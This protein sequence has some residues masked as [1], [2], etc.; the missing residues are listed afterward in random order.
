MRN[1]KRKLNCTI[2]SEHPSFLD[3]IWEH[4]A[5][6][7]YNTPKHP[8]K[9]EQNPMWQHA[10]IS[11]EVYHPTHTCIFGTRFREEDIE[12]WGSFCQPPREA[13]AREAQRTTRE[14]IK[15]AALLTEP[16]LHAPNH[17]PGGFGVHSTDLV[18]TVV[19]LDLSQIRFAPLH[20]APG[21]WLL[22]PSLK[23]CLPLLRGRHWRSRRCLAAATSTSTTNPILK[24]NL[25]AE[26][27]AMEG[28]IGAAGYRTPNRAWTHLHL[29][30]LAVQLY[31]P[32]VDSETR[33]REE[34][35]AEARLP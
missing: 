8:S 24:I 23:H 15:P 7:D 10:K 21:R 1:L 34:Q 5:T 13:K 3:E 25:L 4:E 19:G 18:S 26:R 32:T 28:V 16:L 29:L 6:N 27:K 11:T 35:S 33:D 22:L 30:E 20:L 9:G 2:S 31:S 12:G 14:Q 17:H